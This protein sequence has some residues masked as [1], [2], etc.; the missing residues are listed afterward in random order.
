Q[1]RTEHEWTETDSIDPDLPQH[2]K[3]RC[4]R[5]NKYVDRRFNPVP[6]HTRRRFIPRADG[7]DAV[8]PCRGVSSRSHRGFL[9]RSLDMRERGRNEGVA[10]GVDYQM[11]AVAIRNLSES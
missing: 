5:P 2:G 7:I 11:H 4:G 3:W 8:C 6:E 1:T 10:P 9:H